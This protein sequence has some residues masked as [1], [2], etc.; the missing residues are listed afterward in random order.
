MQPVLVCRVTDHFHRSEPFRRVGGA[1]I[2]SGVR[3]A[4]VEFLKK[5]LDVWYFAIGM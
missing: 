3:L 5:R 2:P 4:L 1:G